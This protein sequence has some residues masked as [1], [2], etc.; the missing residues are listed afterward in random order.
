MK[1]LIAGT[2]T[3]GEKQWETPGGGGQQDKEGMVAPN[4]SGST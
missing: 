3:V 2:A 1:L 4:E